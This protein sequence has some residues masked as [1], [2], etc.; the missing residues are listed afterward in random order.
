MYK[1]WNNYY[2]P[3]LIVTE[4]PASGFSVLLENLLWV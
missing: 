1:Q 2:H 3:T 4:A